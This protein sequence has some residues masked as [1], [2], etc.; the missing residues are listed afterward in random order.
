MAT[1][2]QVK[3]SKCVGSRSTAGSVLTA[4]NQGPALDSVSP[5]LSAPLLLALCL[6]LSL[7]KITKHQN[8]ILR[9]AWVA[10]LVKRPSGSGHGLA[11]CGF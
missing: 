11:V 1:A 8:K 2:V 9:G 3:I 4:E 10:Q 6:S 7:S 5:S